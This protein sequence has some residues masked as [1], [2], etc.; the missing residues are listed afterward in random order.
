MNDERSHIPATGD[1]PRFGAREILKYIGPGFLVTIGFIDPGNWASNLAAGSSFGYTLIWVV[2]LGTMMLMLLQH[3]A[4]HLGIATGYCLSEAAT[5]YLPRK[6]SVPILASAVAAAVSTALAEILGTAIAINMITGLPVRIAVILGCALSFLMLFTNSYRRL[7]K[8]IIGFV[9]VI[10]ISFVFELVLVKADWA[11]ALRGTFVPSMPP[12]SIVLVMSL[13]G[14]VVMPH[15]LY[16]HSEIIQSR[17][18]NLEDGVTI[19]HQLR[20]EFLDT[21]ISMIVGWAINCAIIVL[22]AATFHAGG[23]KV[24]ALDDAKRLLEPLLGKTSGLVFA[25]ALLFSGISSSVTAGMAGG[26]IFTGIYGECYDIEDRHTRRGVIITLAGAAL[27]ALVVPNPFWALVIS[28][29]VLSVQLPFT[30]FTQIFLTSSRKVMG[31]FANRP[32]T[33]VLLLLCG[34]LVSALNVALIASLFHSPR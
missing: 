16:L 25:V 23:I 33:S 4:A 6:A 34:L 10:G 9:S 17:Q 30:I 29:M 19:H 20:F 13:L 14:S 22:A 8:W 5:I 7:E 12:S 31:D 15:N 2:T 3:N 1:S 32:S 26:A 24:E 28:Q 11:A 18:W 27:I 21:M